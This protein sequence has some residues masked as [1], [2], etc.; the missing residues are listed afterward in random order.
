MI[1]DSIANIRKHFNGSDAWTKVCKFIEEMTPEMKDG[2]YV[3]DGDKLYVSVTTYN[4]R[5]HADGVME[6]HR[7]YIDV[8]MLLTGEEDVYVSGIDALIPDIAYDAERDVEF[9]R[10]GGD[11]K[12]ALDPGHFLLLYP[13]DAHMPCISRDNALSPVKKVVVKIDKSQL[14]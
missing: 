6:A 12:I 11:K 7:K 14:A 9:F 4:T 1:H 10:G 2:K 8:Q 13:E 5:L 3:I